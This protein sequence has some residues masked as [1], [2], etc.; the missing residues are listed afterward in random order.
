MIRMNVNNNV[1]NPH[2]QHTAHFSTFPALLAHFTSARRR[3]NSCLV[4][5]ANWTISIFLRG[6][7]QSFVMGF[8]IWHSYWV[9]EWIKENE[10][11]N[12]WNVRKKTYL[13]MSVFLGSLEEQQKIF[14]HHL[15]SSWT[16]NLCPVKLSNYVSLVFTTKTLFITVFRS[17]GTNILT[18]WE[19]SDIHL[20]I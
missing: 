1:T 16:Q 3:T 8:K 17:K 7:R 15:L 4:R 2:T 11:M 19:Q 5:L 10:W 20:Q 13:S 6:E 18:R 9:C 14:K 12:E